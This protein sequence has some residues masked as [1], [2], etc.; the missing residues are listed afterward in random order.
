LEIVLGEVLEKNTGRN[1]FRKALD[2][3][4]D[5]GFIIFAFK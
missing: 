1:F 5:Y 3:G 2:Q 4:T